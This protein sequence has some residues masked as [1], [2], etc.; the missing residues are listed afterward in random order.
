MSSGSVKKKNKDF[1][2][3]CLTLEESLNLAKKEVQKNNFKVISKLISNLFESK[4]KESYGGISN[5]IISFLNLSKK[6]NNADIYSDIRNVP[7]KDLEPEFKQILKQE[8]ADAI[9]SFNN[10]QF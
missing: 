9:R 2:E 4:N 3:N 5:A 8:F 1:L 6:E 7:F 10:N